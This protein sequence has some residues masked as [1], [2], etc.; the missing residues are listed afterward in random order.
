[1]F[2]RP[3]VCIVCNRFSAVFCPR[4][5]SVSLVFGGEFPKDCYN[6]GSL[7]AFRILFH[8]MKTGW[9]FCHAWRYSN[10]GFFDM[11]PLSWSFIVSS[12]LSSLYIFNGVLTWVW[13]R[14]RSGVT[15]TTK[16]GWPP[17][18]SNLA[19]WLIPFATWS[20]ADGEDR[21]L[22]FLQQPPPRPRPPFGFGMRF[23]LI[24]KSSPHELMTSQASAWVRPANGCSLTMKITSPGCR[25]ALAANDPGVIF[26]SRNCW[27]CWSTPPII[28]N[29]HGMSLSSRLSFA[30]TI[31][32]PGAII[33]LCNQIDSGREFCQEDGKLMSCVE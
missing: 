13:E 24:F 4:E 2:F 5:T 26:W 12:R 16:L 25:P 17:L 1:M 32:T 10:L 29:P 20:T 33:T 19:C 8:C 11:K 22:S 14:V 7:L 31:T 21:P 3:G 18:I 28:R 9:V 23:I 6:H 30:L 15:S 27:F